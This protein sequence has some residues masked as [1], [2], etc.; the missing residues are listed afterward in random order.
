M[1][2]LARDVAGPCLAPH[3][4]VLAVGAL[5]G[6]HRGHQALLAR[7]RERAA[8]LHLLPLA[9]SFEPLPRAYF[10]RAPLPR[11]GS[12]RE[13]I[14]GLSA[15]GMSGLLLLRFNAALSAMPADDFVHR[16][17]VAR[18]GA[19]EIWVG[20][21]FRF[22]HQ[23]RGDLALLQHMGAGLG[24]AA[25]ALET[26]LHDGARISSSA[27]RAALTADDFAA[28]AA[29]LG[30]PFCIGGRV[31]RGQQLGR[32]LGYPTANIRLGRR[33][34]PIQGIFAVRVHGAAASLPGGRSGTS[35]AR[36]TGASLP[37]VASLG[38][39][40]TVD[41]REML[42][43]AHLFD[44]NGDLYG[45]H[46]MVEFVRKLR[47]EEKFASL[48]DLT[49]QMHRDAAAARALLGLPLSAHS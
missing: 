34:S 19:R 32:T 39:R 38:M 46:L 37:G 44:F 40:P 10:S 4:S 9:I 18:A 3:G 6:L 24:F 15:A 17:L 43:E 45:R 14:A 1:M 22:G 13:K 42:L 27:I 36:D 5:D 25:H 21:D 41:G 16:V 31:V 20:E 11:L 7:V 2:H 30:Q 48:D 33:V 26:H 23:R 35:C 12:V 28:A 49:R 47:D 8:A 29:L